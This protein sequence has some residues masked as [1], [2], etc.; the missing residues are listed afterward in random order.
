MPV[1]HLS[2]PI[3]CEFGVVR[4]RINPFRLVVPRMHRPVELREICIAGRWIR[5]A[6]R[7]GDTLEVVRAILVEQMD[8]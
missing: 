4:V 5:S 2:R 8:G 3:E 7:G 6:R 1:V